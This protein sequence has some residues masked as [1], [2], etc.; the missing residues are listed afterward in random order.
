MFDATPTMGAIEEAQRPVSAPPTP[1][2]VDT[3]L[4]KPILAEHNSLH[5]SPKESV[6][7]TSQNN[8]CAQVS[9]FLTQYYGTTEAAPLQKP[10]HT[11][12]SNDHF[13]LV[14]VYIGG[15]QFV[16][17]DV[18][19]RMLT[20]K[21]LFAAQGF[22]QDY[23]FEVGVNEHGQ[24]IPLT[25]SAQVRMCGNSVPPAFAKALVEA[26]YLCQAREIASD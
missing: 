18:G 1:K 15:V 7:T 11:I 26:N 2:F 12:T 8:Q 22:P 10:L 17:T 14:N 4:N 19:L 20:P 25:K 5:Q 16:I 6:D 21:E 13:G 23:I 24:K 9:A 3:H